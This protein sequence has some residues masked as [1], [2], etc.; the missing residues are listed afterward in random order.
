MCEGQPALL[1]MAV[2]RCRSLLAAS[3]PLCDVSAMCFSL[4]TD[5]AFGCTN[6][7][8]WTF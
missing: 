5:G 3:L 2:E 8:S 6:G 4:A 1:R 7:A